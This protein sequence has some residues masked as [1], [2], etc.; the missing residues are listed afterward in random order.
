MAG[1]D[2][3][4]RLLPGQSQPVQVGGDFIF[5]KFADRPI[6]VI[7]NGGESSGSRVIMEAGDKYRPGAFQSFEIENT[8]KDNPA[9]LVMTVG[10]GDYNRQIVQGEIMVEPGLR[11]ADGSFVSDTRHEIVIDLYPSKLELTTY[12][13]GEAVAIGSAQ[14]GAITDVS[15][16]WLFL[17]DQDETWVATG[18]GSSYLYIERFSKYGQYLGRLDYSATGFVSAAAFVKPPGEPVLYLDAGVAPI[19]VKRLNDKQTVYTMAAN[20][21]RSV[22]YIPER[23]QY[24]AHHTGTNGLAWLDRSFQV[25]ETFS[26]A[27]P[28]RDWDDIS[29]GYDAAKERILVG[30]LGNLHIL[31]MDGS[32]IETVPAPTGTGA[33]F[34]GYIKGLFTRDGQNLVIQAE[35]AIAQT[36]VPALVALYDYTTKPEFI[37]RRPGCGLLGSPFEA[38]QLPQI[39]ADITATGYYEGVVIEGEII[40]AALEYHFRKEAPA[41]YLDHVYKFSASRQKNGAPFQT[42]YAGNQTF[43]RAN[44]AD[45]FG[46]LLPGRMTITIDN[47]LTMGRDL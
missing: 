41:D 33:G 44:I 9:Q 45:S 20:I 12:A 29:L 5:L 4:K 30:E 1:Q 40:K 13:Q 7:I 24:L 47:A 34:P 25:V 14:P 21:Y 36:Y 8:D 16:V 26:G 28:G 11:K 39:K 6:V 2:I 3:Q 17:G 35:R 37:S 42:Q 23:D 19:Q 38:D 15:D 32:L 18:T 46:V 43:D 22:A 27:F 31:N 10:R